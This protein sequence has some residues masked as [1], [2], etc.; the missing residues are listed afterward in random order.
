M[1]GDTSTLNASANQ[2]LSLKKLPNQRVGAETSMKKLNST[3]SYDILG[4]HR[5]IDPEQLDQ[6]YGALGGRTSG[7]KLG[8]GLGRGGLGSRSPHSFV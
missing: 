8:L 5:E 4:T 2:Q 6:S 7:L 1:G 3:A